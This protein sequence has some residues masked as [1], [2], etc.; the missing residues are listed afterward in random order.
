MQLARRL[1]SSD[2][3]AAERFTAMMMNSVWTRVGYGARSIFWKLI[4]HPKESN[5]PELRAPLGQ[6]REP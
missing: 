1:S 3:P 6:A 4:W 5:T 2:D